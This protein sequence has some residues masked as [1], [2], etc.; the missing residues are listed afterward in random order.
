MDDDLVLNIALDDHATSKHTTDKKS[1]RWTDRFILFCSYYVS[2]ASDA[3]P[4]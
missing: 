4:D 3:L 2:Y 1:G